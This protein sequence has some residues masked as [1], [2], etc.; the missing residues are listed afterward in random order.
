MK[1]EVP[2]EEEIQMHM[3]FP[4]LF[5]D[6]IE[7]ET[8]ASTSDQLL[9]TANVRL[10]CGSEKR[11]VMSEEGWR[12]LFKT[13]C[14]KRGIDEETVTAVFSRYFF[15]HIRDNQRRIYSRCLDSSHPPAIHRELAERGTN[16]GGAGLPQKLPVSHDDSSGRGIV[17]QY[18]SPNKHC[19]FMEIL[20]KEIVCFY[21]EET[22]VLHGS[23]CLKNG[24]SRCDIAVTWTSTTAS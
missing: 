7:S 5:L 22:H 17:I 10:P 21:K 11:T 1:N 14:G 23:A 24:D 3:L 19:R 12:R 8:D 4:K 9:Q 18:A 13:A 2:I 16:R 20:T 6:F 15:R